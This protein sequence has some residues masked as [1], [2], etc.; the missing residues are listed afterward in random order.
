MRRHRPAYLAPSRRPRQQSQSQHQLING[1]SGHDLNIPLLVE[2]P[3]QSAPAVVSPPSS[4]GS[5]ASFHTPSPP[6]TPSRPIRIPSRILRRRRPCR[7]RVIKSCY[8][9][10]H[11][12]LDLLLLIFV[13]IMGL[14][15]DVEV[16]VVKQDRRRA[17]GRGSG[18]VVIQTRDPQE[19]E[20]HRHHYQP[21]NL[22]RS[23][24]QSPHSSL[25]RE[26]WYRD[27]GYGGNIV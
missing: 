2:I 27:T 16:Q 3:Q 18:R 7:R 25:G 21:S 20:R 22:L 11:F 13:C 12:L 19:E 1:G 23:P 4:V 14:F 15:F 17:R 24:P 10:Y 6:R 8:R 5:E 9:L 26:Y